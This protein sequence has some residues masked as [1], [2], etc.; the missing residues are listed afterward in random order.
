MLNKENIHSC[1]VYQKLNKLDLA[2]K[3]GEQALALLEQGSRSLLARA[4]LQLG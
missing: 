1:Q 2:L 3:D 4:H